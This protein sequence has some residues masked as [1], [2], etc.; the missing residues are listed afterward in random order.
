MYRMFR[1]AYIG[2][3]ESETCHRIC[4]VKKWGDH[5]GYGNIGTVAEE[6]VMMYLDNCTEN[7]G[8][9]IWLNHL[10]DQTDETLTVLFFSSMEKKS[11]YKFGLSVVRIDVTIMGKVCS[12]VLAQDESI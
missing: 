6:L 3:K 4:I 7:G 2:G 12:I 1:D 10:W 9:L 11:H 5:L 8:K